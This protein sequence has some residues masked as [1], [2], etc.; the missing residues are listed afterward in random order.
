MK[1]FFAFFG[2]IAAIVATIVGALVIFDRFKNKNRIKDGY[3]K[4]DM[5]EDTEVAE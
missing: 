5:P 1:K 4:C 2:T 3:L